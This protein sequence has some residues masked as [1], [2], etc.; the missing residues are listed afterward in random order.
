MFSIKNTLDQYTEAINSR[1]VRAKLLNYEPEMVGRRSPIA[2]IG[3]LLQPNGVFQLFAGVTKVFLT[4][5]GDVFTRAARFSV[6][7]GIVNLDSP[8]WNGVRLHGR[9][10]DVSL[11]KGEQTVMT[12]PIERGLKG[13]ALLT[14]ES[15]VVDGQIVNTVTLDSVMAPTKLFQEEP[16]LDS[17]EAVKHDLIVKYMGTQSRKLTNG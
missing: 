16:S 7:S 11:L 2:P 14:P 6:S 1:T 12:V 10:I 13:F 8:S 4:T 17:F 9:S 15:K 5:R 3:W